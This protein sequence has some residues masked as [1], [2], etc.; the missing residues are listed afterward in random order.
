MVCLRNNSNGRAILILEYGN[1]LASC[2]VT[3]TC[4]VGMFRGLNRKVIL[5]WEVHILILFHVLRQL[6]IVLYEAAN[7][8][9]SIVGS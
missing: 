1:L 2:C 9:A 3:C 4:T 8:S 6:I 7:S 5:E